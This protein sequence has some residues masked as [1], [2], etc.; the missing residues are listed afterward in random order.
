MYRMDNRWLRNR[1][2]SELKNNNKYLFDSG[3]SGIKISFFNYICSS[4]A[5]IVLFPLVGISFILS[6][7]NIE[8]LNILDISYDTACILVDQRT[9]NIAALLSITLVVVGFLINNLAVKNSISYRILFRASYLYS[10]FYYSISLLSFLFILSSLRD[11][12]NEMYFVRLVVIGTYLTLI[13]L[14][15]LGMLFKNIV[16][17]TQDSYMNRLMHKALIREQ[18]NKLKESCI[19]KCSIKHFSEVMEKSNVTINFYSYI[20]KSKKSYEFSTSREYKDT[21]YCNKKYVR[22]INMHKLNNYI[23]KKKDANCQIFYRWNMGIGFNISSS[24]NGVIYEQGVEQSKKEKKELLSCFKFKIQNNTP[25]QSISSYYEIQFIKA[26]ETNNSIVIKQLLESYYAIYELYAC[27]GI[28]NINVNVDISELVEFA[29]E[30]SIINN[31]DDLFDLL[32]S[33]MIKLETLSLQY[34]R[35]DIYNQYVSIPIWQ[36]RFMKEQFSDGIQLSSKIIEKSIEDASD[37]YKVDIESII[38][39]SDG[40]EL[41][42]LESLNVFSKRAYKS[43]SYLLY[44]MIRNKDLKSF[45]YA[46]GSYNE[47]DYRDEYFDFDIWPELRQLEENNEGGQNYKAIKELKQKYKIR[48]TSYDLQLHGLLGIKSWLYFM[49]S[50]GKYTLDELNQFINVIDCNDRSITYSLDDILFLKQQSF[51]SYMGWEH[52]SVEEMRSG[53]TY[54]SQS[55]FEWLIW[56]IVIDKIKNNKTFFERDKIATENL[57]QISSLYRN[58]KNVVDGIELRFDLWSMIINIENIEKYDEITSELLLNLNRYKQVEDKARIKAIADADIDKTKVTKLYN[59]VGKSWTSGLKIRNLFNELGKEKI[60]KKKLPLF[61][62]FRFRD[63]LKQNFIVSEYYQSIGGISGIGRQLSVDENKLFYTTIK[64]SDYKKLTGDTVL[65]LVDKSIEK[66]SERGINA[67]MIIVSSNKMIQDKSLKESSDFK[68][69]NSRDV[70]QIEISRI[71]LG[72]YKSIAVIGSN[73]NWLQDKV[74]VCDF[75]SSFVMKINTNEDWYDNR[76]EL[77]I[78]ELTDEDANRCLDENP[79][80]WIKQAEGDDLSEEEAILLIK[81]SVV[82]KVGTRFKYEIVDIDSF[83]VGEVINKNYLQ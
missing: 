15:F 71:K 61:G 81:N 82:M 47:I 13:D 56:G 19:Q 4:S 41:K 11:T 57:E 12:F 30:Q 23:K 7:W 67:T 26:V 35:I 43:F 28:E 64:N 10:I 59:E 75:A 52:W 21:T 58:V 34:N 5:W 6:L 74:I 9:G 3:L 46:I 79:N 60:V 53:V 66:L 31:K 73:D 37:K 65:E 17:F 45:T 51:Y 40:A 55:P 50:Q 68:E 77:E 39:L 78:R 48:K 42:V 70:N 8:F 72:D 33:F 44:M 20:N 29:Y 62:F 80:K 36:Y 18:K 76:L 25:S 16:R 22:D 69:N 83:I 49:Y 63:S 38:Y 54:A 24:N 27:T 32:R 1:I 2:I 14:F